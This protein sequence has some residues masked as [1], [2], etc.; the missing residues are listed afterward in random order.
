MAHEFSNI[1]SV[2]VSLKTG[3]SSPLAG[4]GPRFVNAL[5]R[6]RGC[7]ILLTVS[8]N[9]AALSIKNSS[10]T[11]K[12]VFVNI[13]SLLLFWHLIASSQTQTRSSA[14]VDGRSYIVVDFQ[15]SL[16]EFRP[17]TK[18]LRSEVR[19][20]AIPLGDTLGT[21]F[22]CFGRDKDSTLRYFLLHTRT[23]GVTYTNLDFSQVSIDTIRTTEDV[24]LWPNRGTP[25]PLD[26]RIVPSRNRLLFRWLLS[27][28]SDPTPGGRPTPADVLVDV[29]KPFPD[30]LL[31]DL[32]GKDFFT[33]S[34]RGKPAI[35]NWWTTWC[36][37]CI[38]EMP[39]LDSLVSIFGER[40]S[41]LAIAQN[42]DQEVLGFLKNH[43]FRFFHTVGN[44]S[45]IQALGV[46][47]PRTLVLDADGTIQQNLVGGGKET[48]KEVE[49][50]I[51]EVLRH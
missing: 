20:A 34:L 39:G 29:G 38:D 41:F 49:R 33:K 11:M 35:I 25:F 27:P 17:L 16:P 32:N 51:N 7:I 47:F 48:Y 24:R 4:P 14:I 1:E 28:S 10:P 30:L 12:S 45:P 21:M 5:C 19:S 46:K 3:S 2:G 50:A 26:L 42:S 6:K 44:D 18:L 31:V 40:I 9:A 22:I 15:A 8:C 13:L 36:S 43:R 23:D 37:A